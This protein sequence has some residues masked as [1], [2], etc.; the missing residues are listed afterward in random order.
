VQNSVA[1]RI[2]FNAVLARFSGK[3]FGEASAPDTNGSNRKT[4]ILYRKKYIVNLILSGCCEVLEE[5]R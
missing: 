1:S 5:M 4:N 2:Y 3:N